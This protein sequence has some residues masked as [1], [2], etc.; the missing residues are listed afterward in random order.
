MTIEQIEEIIDEV[1]EE[2][3]FQ[4][5]QTSEILKRIRDLE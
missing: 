2:D 4:C 1:T 5:D 3:G